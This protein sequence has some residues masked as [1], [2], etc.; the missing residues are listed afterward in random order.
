MATSRRLNLQ[1][2]ALPMVL[3]LLLLAQCIAASTMEPDFVHRSYRYECG[4]DPEIIALRLDRER[5]QYVRVVSDDN[6]DNNDNN[7]RRELTVLMG[8]RITSSGRIRGNN[9]DGLAVVDDDRHGRDLVDD[10]VVP[11]RACS[12]RDI[13][14]V[15]CPLRVDHCAVI[16]RY[17]PTVHGSLPLGCVDPVEKKD[18]FAETTFMIVVLWFS[19]LLSCIICTH[20]GRQ[21]VHFF[22]SSC[23]PG[24]NPALAWF[25]LRTDRELANVMMHRHVD[26]QRHLMFQRLE[27]ISSEL[28]ADILN[29]RDILDETQHPIQQAIKKKQA[30]TLALKTRILENDQHSAEKAESNANK[31]EN[32]DDEVFDDCIICFQPLESG[33][34][35]G[36]LPCKHLFHADC[37]KTWL[38]RRNACPLCNANQIASPRFNAMDQAANESTTQETNSITASQESSSQNGNGSE[39]PTTVDVDA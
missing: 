30:G 9:H 23:I 2:N 7:D 38:K 6:D 31:E 10:E 22:L 25:I 36:D 16:R 8:A 35:V 12:C 15:Y 20:W 3:L 17:D 13:G 14:P 39:A 5:G 28:A 27:H 24:Y 29:G 19:V 4:V 33:D 18:E 26:S 11:V 1:W 34:R 21:L 32:D 37:L